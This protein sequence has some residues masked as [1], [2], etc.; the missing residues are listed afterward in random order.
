LYTELAP[1][2]GGER[3]KAKIALISAMYGGTAGDAAALVALMRE[4]FPA[5][6]ECVERAAR[7]GEKGGIVRTWLGR[8]VPAPS[9][10][11]WSE[12]NSDKGIRAATRRGRFTRNFIVQGTAAEWALVLLALLR[13]R[14]H[15]DGLGELVFYLHDE[16]MV[17]CPAAHAPAVC[18]AIET[19]AAGAT[20]TLFGDMPVRIP[21]R[22]KII[23]SYAEAK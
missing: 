16:F 13:R 18:E 23:D 9:A 12:L 22:P 21:L 11:W 10:K 6:A 8:T 7:T 15:E 2:L 19:A 1:D 20:R 4:R 3:A 14:L 5:A 17:H